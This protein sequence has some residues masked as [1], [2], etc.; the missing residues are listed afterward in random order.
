MN[1]RVEECIPAF[2]SATGSESTDSQAVLAALPAPQQVGI[3][4][5]KWVDL[6]QGTAEAIGRLGRLR[7]R[8]FLA[9]LAL[10]TLVP[11][12]GLPLW[13]SSGRGGFPGL[14]TVLAITGPMHVAA[15]SFFY[16]DRDFRPVLRESPWRCVFSIVW[17]PSAI[18]LAGL[19]AGA[20]GGRPWGYLAVF[21]FHN[22]WLFYHYQRQNFGLVSFVS[23]RVGTGRLPAQ[24]N[25]ALNLSAF[26]GYLSMLGVPGFLSLGAPG[27]LNYTNESTSLQA[28]LVFWVLGAVV[29]TLSIVVMIR[30]LLREPRLR[31]S[32]WVV[33][34]LIVSLGFFLP[35]LVSRTIALGFLPYAIAHG[36]QYILMMG[37]ASGRSSRGWMAL[38][39]M[40]GLGA[41]I[42]LTINAMTA[43]PLIFVNLGLVEVHFMVDA[44]VWRLRE[45]K[46]R[47]IMNDRFDFL[48]AS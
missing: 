45:P 29:Y 7:S 44:K 32:G 41:M 43:W 38:L 14:L 26:G 16:T 25:T 15:T 22:A 37:I 27:F 48:L 19:V 46:Q 10:V 47:A 5:P 31:A 8:W 24:V 28:T 2:G 42:G 17:L 9:A 12:V 13:L 11:L 3:S 6:D 33:G 30:V 35:S 40:C 36:A 18:L 23:S 34:G 21:S 20:I 4:L 39:T 1:P